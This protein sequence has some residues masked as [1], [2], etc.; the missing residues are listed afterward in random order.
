M[1]NKS[2]SKTSVSVNILGKGA[3]VTGDV[4]I[5]GDFRLDGVLDGN[6]K[7]S[8]R[9]VIGPEGK[10]TGNVQSELADISGEVKGDVKIKQT[11][12]LLSTCRIE[13]DVECDKLVVDSG[14]QFNG[15][16]RMGAKLKN[17]KE[18]FAEE[19]KIHEAR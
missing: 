2:A 5:Q 12:H 17:L 19:K 11:L 9:L 13:G 10:I 18:A 6:L 4:Q 8:G 3:I 14:A 1:F 15:N 7:V 16:C